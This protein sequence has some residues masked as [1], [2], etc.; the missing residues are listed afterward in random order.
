MLA[1]TPPGSTLLSLYAPEVPV[2]GHRRSPDPWQLSSF[3]NTKFFDD[4]LAGGLAGYADRISL[5]Q[6]ALIAV[7]RRATV[8][9]L[10]P[11]LDREYAR[12]GRGQFWT[13]YASKTLGRP[14]VHHLREVNRDTTDG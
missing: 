2:L 1:A 4:H 13:W 5:M 10:Q 6:P 12:V 14:G 7:G 9:W 8:G 3:A 11:V